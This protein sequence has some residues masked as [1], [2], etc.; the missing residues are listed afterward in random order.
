[1]QNGSNQEKR[2]FIRTF[3]RKMEFNPSEESITIYWYA[4][5]VQTQNQSIDTMHTNKV[6]FSSGV[7][8]GT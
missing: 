6:W 4:D 7:G 1:M 5:P 3:I 2:E 8:G